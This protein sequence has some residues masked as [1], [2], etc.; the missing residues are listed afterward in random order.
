MINIMQLWSS[1]SNN[2]EDVNLPTSREGLFV[3][4]KFI[5]FRYMKNQKYTIKFL[6][7]NQKIK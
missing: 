1:T 3:W 7:K 6:N 4:G 2:K 5:I